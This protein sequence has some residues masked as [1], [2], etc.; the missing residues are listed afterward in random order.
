MVERKLAYLFPGQGSQS[1]GM[2]RDLYESSRR[3]RLTFEE[4][5][6]ALKLPLSRLCFEGPEEELRQTV[7]AQPAIMTVSLALLRAAQ[8]K[9]IE[10]QPLFVAG[11][12][13]GEYTALAASGVL[14]FSDALR[15]V[16]ERG[17]LMQEAGLSQPGGMAAI[18][19]LDEA[20]L[21][22]I[23]QETG[24]QIANLNS[25]DQIVISGTRE[26][27]AQ[28]MDLARAR[29]ARRTVPLEVS[30][31]FHSSLMEPARKG[32]AQAISRLKFRNPRI[33]I[34]GNCTAR[35]LTTSLEVKVELL[36]QTCN[37]VQWHRSVQYMVQAGVS[38]FVEVGP[39]RVLTGLVK[40]IDDSVE[41]LN[42]SD[43]VSLQ[44][45]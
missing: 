5:D 43:T 8:E 27:L 44:A 12:S 36:R 22:E 41:V 34:V 38:T 17:R 24:A 2:G 20:S 35:P 9:G 31:A 14:T 3:A 18:L 10:G 21:E 39:G 6:R 42:I 19:G 13:M 28:A 25:P 29:G 4:A 32:I 16:R 1:V 7:N 45:L 15:L 11:H 26:T 33:P 37:C 23:C 40:K 30:A